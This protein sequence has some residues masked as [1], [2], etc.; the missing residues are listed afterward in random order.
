MQLLVQ[1]DY[2]KEPKI[3][4]KKEFKVNLK[5]DVSISVLLEFNSLRLKI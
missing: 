5:S 2:P 1:I 3:W 4:N